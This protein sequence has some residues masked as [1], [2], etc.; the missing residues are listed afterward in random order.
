MNR[1]DFQKLAEA[2]LLDAKALFEGKRFDAAY[3]LA[4]YV[5]ECALKACA[6][7][8]TREH[9][10][11]PKNTGILYRHNLEDLVKASGI[12][13]SFSKDRDSDTLLDQYWEFVKDWKSD[14][15]YELRDEH[16]EVTARTMLSAI[17]DREHG[18]LQCLSK[19]W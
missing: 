14:S 9:Y 2:R 5:V 11:P 15:R 17:E 7:K 3:Y 18:V 1:L 12:G 4:G 13:E 8:L 10:F 16:A 19:Y 6:A